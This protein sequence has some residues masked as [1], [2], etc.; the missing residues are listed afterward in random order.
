MILIK[1]RKILAIAIGCTKL[2]IGCN[3]T[4]EDTQDK[5]IDK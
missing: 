3:A 5:S 1:Y 4:T 2:R